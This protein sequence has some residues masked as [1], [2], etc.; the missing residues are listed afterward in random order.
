MS[1]WLQ[2]R[3]AILPALGLVPSAWLFHRWRQSLQLRQRV[4]VLAHGAVH[5]LTDVPTSILLTALGRLERQ[6]RL[7]EQKPDP[8]RPDYGVAL[9]LAREGADLE[10][11]ASRCGLPRDEARLVMQMHSANS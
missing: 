2:I 7:V 3:M 5:A 4:G 6:V 10:Q 1:T 11:L 8:T 9:Q